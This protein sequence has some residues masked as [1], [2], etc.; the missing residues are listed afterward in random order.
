VP[1]PVGVGRLVIPA[2]QRAWGW[3]AAQ[4]ELGDGIACFSIHWEAG[5]TIA[6][7]APTGTPKQALILGMQ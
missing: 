3:R 1:A 6:S 5:L 7:D 2:T 4:S